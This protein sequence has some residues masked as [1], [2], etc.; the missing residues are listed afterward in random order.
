VS[1]D[2]GLPRLEPRRLAAPGT[3]AGDILADGLPVRGLLP[4]PGA[5]AAAGSRRRPGRIGAGAFRSASGNSASKLDRVL[6]GDGVIVS[7]GQQPVLFL[8]P[9]YVVYKALTAVAN[10]A[11][12]EAASGRPALACFWVAADD[13]DWQEVARAHAV[14]REGVIRT[15][16]IAPPP[17]R[18]GCSVGPTVLPPETGTALD[19]YLELVGRTEFSA[20]ALRPLRDGFRPG[21]TFAGAFVGVLAELLAGLDIVILDA[22]RPE[23]KSAAA[24][25]LRRCLEDA[26]GCAAAFEAGTA[27]VAAA[28]HE[29]R[30][31]PPA[32]GTQVFHEAERR[33]HVV[34]G[35]DGR[36]GARDRE[37]EPLACWLERLDADP[38]RFSA[39]A[40][41]RPALESW[42]LP[43]A[44]TALGP[45]ELEYWAQL[46]PLFAHL[47]VPLPEV[48]P[49]SSWRLVEP[50]VDRWL[51]K[52]AAAAAE[53]AD[54][55]DAVVRRLVAGHRPPSV[56]AAIEKLRAGL[57]R[58]FGRVEAAAGEEL[59][60]IRSAVGKAR[61]S[62][63]DSVS[64]LEGTVDA[65]V[66]ERQEIL[67]SQARRAAAHLYPGG[68][69]QERVV[70]PWPFLARYGPGFLSEL[71]EAHGLAPQEGR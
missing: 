64:E 50:R 69:P 31:R 66:R 36:L 13:H 43:V 39:G 12:I 56:A 26:A 40:A 29:P 23:V 45:G 51:G 6:A 16:T 3:L 59:P 4:R 65:R 5:D 8:G 20:E 52:V 62:A 67:V 34:R 35:A 46:G 68:R 18:D 38:G 44:R 57:D 11:R 42:L 1:V 33:E 47:D 49:R 27:R 2:A 70:G 54:G 63:F 48:V 32:G 41:L 24:P 55:G 61:K 30:L 53:L 71:V 58:D 19:E 28:G 22:S 7:T 14:D 15:I 60:G 21:A 17:D 37:S 25:F 9:L 10:A